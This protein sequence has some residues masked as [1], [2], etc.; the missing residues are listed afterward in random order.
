MRWQKPVRCKLNLVGAVQMQM[1]MQTQIEQKDVLLLFLSIS[2]FA[3][4]SMHTSVFVLCCKKAR[5]Q[6]A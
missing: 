4:A 6:R 3:H 1:Q 5:D 2:P